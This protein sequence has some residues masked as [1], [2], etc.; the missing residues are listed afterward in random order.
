MEH[1]IILQINIE[2]KIRKQHKYFNKLNLILTLIDRI[3]RKDHGC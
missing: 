3:D 2:D 1:S